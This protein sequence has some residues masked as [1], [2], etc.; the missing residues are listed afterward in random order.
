MVLVSFSLFEVLGIKL[1]TCLRC[2]IQLHSQHGFEASVN[3]E[4]GNVSP[5]GKGPGALSLNLNT[6]M[7]ARTH[8]LTWWVN[9]LQGC[10][11]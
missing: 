5:A 3:P 6:R 8:A 11:E 9:V 7:H 1:G 2:V 10:F 4:E